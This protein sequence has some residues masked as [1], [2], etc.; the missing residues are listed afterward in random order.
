MQSETQKLKKLQRYTDTTLRPEAW[1]KFKRTE[2][3]CIPLDWKRNSF[4]AENPRILHSM[5]YAGGGEGRSS[6]SFL[7]FPPPPRTPGIGEMEAVEC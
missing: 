6:T 2:L 5:D 1:S 4:R 3:H 7:H